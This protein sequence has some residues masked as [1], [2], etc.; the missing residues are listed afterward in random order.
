MPCNSSP[1]PDILTTEKNQ[2][3][4]EQ[5]F[6]WPTTVSIIIISKPAASQSVMVSSFTGYAS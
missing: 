3:Y 1:A 6:L 4:C 5:L 2:P